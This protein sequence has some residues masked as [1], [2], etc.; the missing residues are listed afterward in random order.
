MKRLLF[1]LVLFFCCIV[2]VNASTTSTFHT[3]DWISNVY[4]NKVKNGVIHYKQALFIKDNS[5]GIAYCVEPFKNLNT[6]K[7][8]TGY[9]SDYAK[10]LGISNS[11]W[12]KISLIAYYGYGYGNHTSDRW[13]A[14]T[15]VMIWR[16]IDKD[17]SFYFT[18]KLNGSKITTYDNDIKEIESLVN[19]HNKISSFAFKTYD[20]SINSSNTLIDS[21]SMLDE[22]NMSINNSNISVNKNGSNLVINTNKVGSSV[23]SFEK[24]F[25]NYNKNV[26]VFVDSSYQNVMTPGNVESLKFDIKVNVLSGSLKITKVDYDSNEKIPSGEG[27]LI[28]SQYGLYDISDKLIYNLVI[29]EKNESLVDNLPFGKYYVKEM[30]S[31]KG[32]LLDEDKY[33]FEINENSLNVDLLL[34]NKAIKSKIEINKYFGDKLESGISFE[35]RNSKDEIVDIVTTNDNGK[36]IKELYY[37]KYKFHQINSTKNYLPV[38]D[39]EIIIDETTS[40]LISLNLYDEEFSTKVVI[41]KKD[42][43]SGEVIKEETIFKLFDLEKKEY[44]KVNDSDELKTVDGILVIDKLISGNYELNEYKAP[45]GYKKSDKKLK[46]IIDDSYKYELDQDNYPMYVVEYENDKELIEVEVPNTSL[47]YKDKILIFEDKKKKLI[48]FS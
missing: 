25:T 12:K 35:I 3:G 31:M 8:Y 20:Y 27:E 19:N 48:I 41:I 15:Q 32:Y 10:H 2:Y 17:A 11:V 46:I 5:G 28:G 34:K 38:D 29:D 45:I 42:S 14:I 43:E 33:F 37:G 23:I 9:D 16:E 6:S 24:K 13:F 7:E 4:I 39:F 26:F 22:F 40:N 36:I 1:V 18:D 30:F 21:N 44:Y 47:D